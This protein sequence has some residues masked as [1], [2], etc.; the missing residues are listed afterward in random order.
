M[1]ISAAVVTFNEESN[2]ERCL[3][4]LDFC[5]E[6]VIVDSKS[7]DKTVSIA[8]KHTKN[9]FS[10]DFTGFS[11][12]KN[13]ALDRCKNPW[14]LSIDADEEISSALKEKI[15]E[16]A[17]VNGALDGYYIKRSDFF[18]GRQ[19]GHC[20]CDRDYQ[21]RLFKKSKG[22]FDGKPVH[23]SVKIN[24]ATGKINE[25]IYHY[26]YP[27]S[28]V[29]FNK[30]NRYTSMQADEKRKG[31]LVFRIL[32]APF[33]KFFRMYFLKAGFL[34]GFQGFVLSV[35]SGFSEFVKFAKMLERAREAGKGAILLRAPNW[36]GD[37]VMMT[38]AL[39]EAK[40]LYKKVFV[41]VPNAGVK[42]ILEGNPYIERI[43]QY[44]RKSLRSTLQAAAILKKENIGT[45]VSFSPSLSSYLF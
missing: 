29:Y 6:I 2:L 25:I 24:G 35:Y 39:R 10:R 42:E 20:G 16:I 14:I 1:K 15:K 18:L 23:E 28:L 32:F 36:I 41:A 12:I 30:M 13:F 8:R 38:F 7:T 33:L 17:A 5:D 34:D 19:I 21:L 44:D 45:G 9:I 3:K 27:N 4:S 22:R 11:D 43:I 26:S 40:R 31:M 37:A